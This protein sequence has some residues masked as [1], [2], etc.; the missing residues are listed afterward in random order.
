MRTVFVVI[1]LNF[2]LLNLLF[3]VVGRTV[4]SIPIRYVPAD[5]RYS[6]QR[7]AVTF[8]VHAVA[9][10]ATVEVHAQSSGGWVFDINLSE[11]GACVESVLEAVGGTVAYLFGFSGDETGVDFSI[12]HDGK[13]QEIVLTYNTRP[14]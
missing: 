10:G 11:S 14:D 5:A 13:A 3:F 9:P 2:L 8:S 4:M 6:S 7:P 12:T 1:V